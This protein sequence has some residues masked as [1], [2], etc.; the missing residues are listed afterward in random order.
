[1]P[2]FVPVTDVEK[3]REEQDDSMDKHRKF[4]NPYSAP[5]PPGGK[6]TVDRGWCGNCFVALSCSLA[7]Q[8]LVAFYAALLCF[9]L[10]VH[11]YFITILLSC[12]LA[13]LLSRSLT[14]W[15]SCSLALLLS[16]SSVDHTLLPP[17]DRLITCAASS[18]SV[19]PNAPST[20]QPRVP[21]CLH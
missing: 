11:S 13:L 21:A 8:L 9:T 16:C 4:D 14:L 19:P 5:V 20:P 7:D 18:R 15:F 2:R 6:K 1:M 17:S 10:L 12:S 3:S